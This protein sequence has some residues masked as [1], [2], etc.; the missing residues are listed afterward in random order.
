MIA[1]IRPDGWNLSLLLHVAG[2]MV[3]VG[4]LAAVVTTLVLSRRGDAA[5]LARL[6]F[7]TLLFA[8][9]PAFV[10]MRAGAEWIASKEDPPD[11]S[12]WIG[13]G[14]TVSDL[15]LLILIVGTILLAVV[16]RRMRRRGGDAGTLGQVAS[17][18]VAL[19]LVGYAVAIWA[20]TTKPD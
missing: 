13:I 14:Y 20:M 5:V 7:R 17:A 3:L 10:A 11:D 15:G 18:L 6:G 1:A 4:S 19:T 12:T 16:V 9:L 8:A 2:A